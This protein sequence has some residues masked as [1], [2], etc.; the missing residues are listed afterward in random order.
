MVDAPLVCSSYTLGT[1]VGFPDRVRAAATAGY[2]GIGLRAENYWDAGLDDTAMLAVAEQ[3]GLRILEV[4]YLTSWGT[5]ADRNEAQQEKERTVF[6]MARAFGVRHLNAGLLEKLPLVV[7]IEAFAGLCERAG[8]DLTV[9]LEFMPYS[10]V[11]DLA[12]AWRIVEPV[13]NAALIIDGWHWARAGQ[14]AADLVEV[15]PERIVSV[16]LCDV[17]AEPMEPLRAESLGHRL[18][19]GRGYGDTVGLLRALA[20]HGVV[21][22]VMAV[23]VISDELVARGVDVAAQVTAD[24]A[25]AV[26]AAAVV[27]GHG[28]R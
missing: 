15:P 18:P 25:R 23:E 10:G 11:P 13:P 9:A 19:P 5:T 20:A 1:E 17:R 26:L 7:V 24:A 22:A 14:Q 6:S 16:Q 27:P 2:D 4:E 28:G 12:T 3:H 8:H 21:P